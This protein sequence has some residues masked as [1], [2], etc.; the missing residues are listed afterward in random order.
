MPIQPTSKSN[1]R[2]IQ[3]VFNDEMENYATYSLS[4]PNYNELNLHSR[5]VV[6]KNLPPLFIEQLE[7]MQPYNSEAKNQE[8]N[9]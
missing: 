2:P 1:N 5:K 4:S 7:E 8:H 9:Q 3:L 6:E